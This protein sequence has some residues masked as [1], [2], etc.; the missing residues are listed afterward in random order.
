M[1]I[2]GDITDAVCSHPTLGDFRFSAKA[3]EAF[4]C[5]KGGIRNDDSSD[6]VT[7]NGQ[8]IVKKTMVR[9]SLEGNVAVDMK[10]DLEQSSL[11]ALAASGDP[12][13]WILS[14]LSGA[15]WK[16]TGV[17][18]GDLIIDTNTAQLK[19]KVAGGGILESIA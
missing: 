6:G 18:V 10:S 15:V 3:G 4:N 7:G 11:N 12:G 8:L 13:I 2:G 5:D 14:S 9:W 1:Y 19:L 16:G 17:P